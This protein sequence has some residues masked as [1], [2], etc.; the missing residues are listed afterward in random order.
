MGGIPSLSIW[1]ILCVALQM[2]LIGLNRPITELRNSRNRETLGSH[3]VSHSVTVHVILQHVTLPVRD[4][5]LFVP[6][7]RRAGHHTR[8]TGE[9]ATPGHPPMVTRKPR[10]LNPQGTDLNVTVALQDH[11]RDQLGPAQSASIVTATDTGRATVHAGRGETDRTESQPYQPGTINPHA[12]DLVRKL[13][14]NKY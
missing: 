11:H 1:T 13:D 5:I 8:H 2:I 7:G 14:R 10:P 9:I 12:K 6:L 4:L 3:T